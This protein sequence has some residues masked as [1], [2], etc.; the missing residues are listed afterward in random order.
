MSI[1]TVKI[2]N[3]PS[4]DVSWFKGMNTQQALE[5][6]YNQQ[7]PTDKFSFSLQYYGSPLGYL[8]TM[9]DNLYETKSSPIYY[10]EFY[11]NGKASTTGIDN[12]ILKENDTVTFTYEEYSENKHKNTT[13]GI[14]HTLNLN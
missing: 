14:K 6:A 3:G 10:W 1:V 5:G 12:T 13:V 11:L 8:V 2:T 9:I 7:N 4:I